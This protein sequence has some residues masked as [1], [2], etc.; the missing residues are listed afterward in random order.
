M[1]KPTQKE[2]DNLK[3]PVTKLRDQTSNFK[4]STQRKVEAQLVSLMNSTKH[5]KQNQYQFTK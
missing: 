1:T 3:R 5:L 2:T 4:I